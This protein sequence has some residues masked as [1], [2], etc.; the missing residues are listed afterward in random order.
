M[1]QASKSGPGQRYIGEG[2]D[3]CQTLV[4]W[5]DVAYDQLID[6]SIDDWFD[7]W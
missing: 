2:V 5:Q 6:Y 3:I 7:W 1:E 4:N